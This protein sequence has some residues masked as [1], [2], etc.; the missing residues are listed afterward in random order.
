MKVEK[1]MKVEK[2]YL[3]E[4]EPIFTSIELLDIF[5]ELTTEVFLTCSDLLDEYG[6]LMAPTNVVTNNKYDG[7]ITQ[8]IPIKL[9]TGTIYIC[10]HEF[11]RFNTHFKWL[12]FTHND[13]AK[14]EKYTFDKVKN[15]NIDPVN[16]WYFSYMRPGVVFPKHIDGKISKLRFLHSVKQSH[17]D[18]SFEYNDKSYYFPENSSYILNGEVPHNIINNTLYDRLMYIG[19]I[20]NV[21]GSNIIKKWLNE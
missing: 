9:K 12:H 19:T 16:S 13:L 10:E 2:E 15:S 8:V 5:N 11:K 14:Y 20:T 1:V 21:G 3:V 18:V 6:F 4:I 7:E 17:S